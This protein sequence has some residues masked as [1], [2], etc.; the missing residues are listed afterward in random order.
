MVNGRPRQHVK[1]RLAEAI[2]TGAIPDTRDIV[3]VSI[4]EARG[5]LGYVW[6]RT[7][8][9]SRRQRIRTLCNLETSRRKVSG[10][11]AGLDATRR[12][13]IGKIV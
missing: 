5:L 1:P 12:R 13:D 4:A 11:I 3:L 2:L 6:S 8:L 9:H 7:Q 10:A